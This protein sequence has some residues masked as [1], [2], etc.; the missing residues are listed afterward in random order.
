MP[1]TD[2]PIVTYSPAE[3][4]RRVRWSEDAERT[5]QRAIEELNE[6]NGS[7]LTGTGTPEVAI[8]MLCDLLDRLEDSRTGEE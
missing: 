5:V 2:K 4:A 8:Q 3:V 7:M 6:L 1:E